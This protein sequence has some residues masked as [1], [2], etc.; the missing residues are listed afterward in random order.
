MDVGV[1]GI[2][3]SSSKPARDHAAALSNCLCGVHTF[4]FSSRRSVLFI[5]DECDASITDKLISHA[6]ITVCNGHGAE[7][8]YDIC[9]PFLRMTARLAL[10]KNSIFSIYSFSLVFWRWSTHTCILHK[11]HSHQ[12]W[13]QV[14]LQK[15]Y[16]VHSRL[17]MF[18][19]NAIINSI[20]YFLWPEFPVC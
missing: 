15:T 8:D 11:S 14:R 4:P 1:F 19:A 13:A 17:I 10:A 9:I 16:R 5:S 2:S 12:C 20:N 3:P 6:I 7:N 18:R